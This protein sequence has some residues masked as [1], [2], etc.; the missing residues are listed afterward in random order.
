MSDWKRVS[1]STTWTWAISPNLQAPFLFNY[2]GKPWLTQ[3]YSRHVLDTFYN[4]SPYNAW[5]GEEDEGQ[6]S[7]LFV[8]MALGLFERFLK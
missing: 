7:S 5:Q 8:L 3:K 2:S 6:L 4:N 1:G